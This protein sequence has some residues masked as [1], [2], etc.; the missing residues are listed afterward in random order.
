MKL[1]KVQ[2]EQFAVNRSMSS[3]MLPK[4]SLRCVEVGF[5]AVLRLG[6]FCF[7]FFVFASSEKLNS[8]NIYVN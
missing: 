6:G 8:M 5:K 3:S 2:G 1:A 7:L 4:A